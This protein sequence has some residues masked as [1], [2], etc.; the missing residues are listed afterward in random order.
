MRYAL[1]SL[2]KTKEN[3]EELNET[4][5]GA[6]EQEIKFILCS[7]VNILRVRAASPGLLNIAGGRLIFDAIF[8]PSYLSFVFVKKGSLKK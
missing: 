5:N 2:D 4:D 1:A 8:N 6:R 3:Q 7:F